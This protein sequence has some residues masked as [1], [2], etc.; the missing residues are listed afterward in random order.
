[1]VMSDRV[2]TSSTCFLPFGD[3]E[4]RL[5][6]QARALLV[7]STDREGGQE[8]RLASPCSPNPESPPSPVIL[9]C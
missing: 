9:G 4:P 5:L 7:P 8:G 6:T 2:L 1:M 3:C